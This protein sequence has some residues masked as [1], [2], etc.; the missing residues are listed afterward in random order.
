[1]MKQ[2]VL[3]AMTTL[4]LIGCGLQPEAAPSTGARE[5]AIKNPEIE[6][7]K[8][9]TCEIDPGCDPAVPTH[10]HDREVLM[11]EGCESHWEKET[12]FWCEEG[13]IHH[14]YNYRFYD[15]DSVRVNDEGETVC[16]YTVKTWTG[17]FDT[18]IND[19]DECE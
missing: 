10:T 8:D 13:V 9:A 19:G 18:E 1:M 12:S 4:V 15:L 5:S 11:G 2:S 17:Q 6:K 16:V 3:F 7:E 14:S